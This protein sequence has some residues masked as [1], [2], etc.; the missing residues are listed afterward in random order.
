MFNVFKRK[1]II[2]LYLFFIIFNLLQAEEVS[3]KYFNNIFAG[4]KERIYSLESDTR[5]VIIY[6]AEVNISLFKDYSQ[7]NAKY[8]IK[9][10][11]DDI[12]LCFA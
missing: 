5:S 6:Y 1:L 2:F 7:I 9:N 4:G 3:K 8:Y 11:G 12:T 10:K